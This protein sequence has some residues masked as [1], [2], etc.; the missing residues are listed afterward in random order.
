MRTGVSRF[1]GNP[2]GVF[3]TVASCGGPKD[4][5]EAWVTIAAQMKVLDAFNEAKRGSPKTCLMSASAAG[6]VAVVKAL[7]KHGACARE[8]NVLMS[9]CQPSS[10]VCHLRS[11]AL[12]FP[13]AFPHFSMPNYTQASATY[14]T[15]ITIRYIR[16]YV[17]YCI[18]LSHVV[19][20][21]FDLGTSRVKQHVLHQPFQLPSRLGHSRLQW[22]IGQDSP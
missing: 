21:T 11:P 13:S 19:P 6:D 9:I 5:V 15:Y 1:G 12:P 2:R 10:S 8:L 17:P 7:L 3:A 20:P 14:H 4:L 18:L 16:T 22:Q